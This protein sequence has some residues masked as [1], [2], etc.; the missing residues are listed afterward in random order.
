MVVDSTTF[1]ADTKAD[2]TAAT[3]TTGEDVE[4][5]QER[6]ATLVYERQELRGARADRERLE[7]NRRE[8][9]DLQQQLS[10]ALIARHT[11]APQPAF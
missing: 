2:M 8:I 6:I 5:L 3:L 11:P 9:A 10:R 1:L 7:H 4:A